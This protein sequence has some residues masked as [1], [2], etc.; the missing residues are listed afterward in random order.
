MTKSI[1]FPN[2]L[3]F[4]CDLFSRVTEFE[5]KLMAN[6]EELE[7]KNIRLGKLHLVEYFFFF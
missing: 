3:Y 4:S 5:G 6:N 7:M 1:I 2:S